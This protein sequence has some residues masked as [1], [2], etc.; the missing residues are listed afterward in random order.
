MDSNADLLIE[1][2]A[3][4]I[5]TLVSGGFDS[6]LMAVLTKE[7]GIVQYPL[8]I[9]YGQL[10]KEAELKACLAI[11]KNYDLPSPQIMNISGFGRLI[12]SGLTD[13]KARL[14]ED[15][16]L[17]GRNLLFLV[18]ASAYAYQ[19]K[20]STVAIGLLNEECRLFPDQ[21]KAFIKKTEALINLAIGGDIKI[22][23]PLIE[24][25]KSDVIKLANKKGIKGSYSC[26]AG[27]FPPCGKCISCLEIVNALRNKKEVK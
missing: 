15:A 13:T 12:S 25:T 2:F 24:F 1:A 9:D 23:T 22:I 6:T 16:F 8:F 5:V 18:I 27:T 10:C 3:V 20:S 19:T 11:H 7:E 14:N 4:S 17:P 21:T 26:H